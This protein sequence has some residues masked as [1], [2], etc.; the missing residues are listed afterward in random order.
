MEILSTFEMNDTDMSWQD[1]A[2][3]KDSDADFF[4]ES[5]YNTAPIKAALAVCA[6]CSVRER[7]LQFAMDNKIEHGIWGGKT[8]PNRSTLRRYKYKHVRN[9]REYVPPRSTVIP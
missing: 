4:P 1:E 3:C 5:G 8:A 9:G 2:A 7:C 6:K